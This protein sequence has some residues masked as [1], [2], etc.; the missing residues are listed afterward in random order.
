MLSYSLMGC[1]QRRVEARFR[2]VHFVAIIFFPKQHKLS[3]HAARCGQHLLP[4]WSNICRS[5]PALNF[6]IRAL[7]LFKVSRLPVTSGR[8]ASQ[9][10]N[11]SRQ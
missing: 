3:R 5:Q 1:L 9:S 6:E 2:S 4:N 11:C 10:Y 8:G 7:Q